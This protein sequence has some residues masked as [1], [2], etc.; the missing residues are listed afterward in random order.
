MS[1]G[2]LRLRCHQEAAR[3]QHQQRQPR[4]LVLLVLNDAALRAETL[5]QLKYVQ[6]QGAARCV[7]CNSPGLQHA[8]LWLALWR[9]GAM[10]RYQALWHGADG[11]GREQAAWR[12][13]AGNVPL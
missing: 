10:W 12:Q 7:A 5:A 13:R 9:C 8:G 4:Q 2:A 11:A 6:L 1:T 3:K